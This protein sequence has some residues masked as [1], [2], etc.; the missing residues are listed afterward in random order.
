MYGLGLTAVQLLCSSDHRLKQLFHCHGGSQLLMAMS[1][2]TDGVLHK[3]VASTL[4]CVTRSIYFEPLYLYQQMKYICFS[5]S[6][7][8]NFLN[9]FHVVTYVVLYGWLYESIFVLHI[10][11]SFC[12]VGTDENNDIP[13]NTKKTLDIWDHVRIYTNYKLINSKML[14]LSEY[15]SHKSCL[16]ELEI[17]QQNIQ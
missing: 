4:H 10:S 16:L 5:N 7:I 2:Y 3:E 15:L 8:C 9:M 12:F 13:R 14:T 1:S 6:M 17:S 11:L